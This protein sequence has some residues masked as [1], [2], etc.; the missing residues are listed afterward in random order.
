MQVI[1]SFIQTSFN[2]PRC[3]PGCCWQ[4]STDRLLFTNTQRRKRVSRAKQ[5]WLDRSGED[6]PAQTDRL[7]SG[8]TVALCQASRA[9]LILKREV[10]EQLC[11]G[12][13][14]LFSLVSLYI[15]YKE[16]SD[17]CCEPSV[18]SSHKRFCAKEIQH[19]LDELWEIVIMLPAPVLPCIGV[20]KVHWPTVSWKET[21]KWDTEFN[22]KNTLVLIYSIHQFL[23]ICICQKP[24]YLKVG[25]WNFWK[26]KKPNL[27]LANE[28][29]NS[30]KIK[31]TLAQFYALRGFA[32]THMV[33]VWPVV[34]SQL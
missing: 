14:S 9:L 29:Y 19:C 7:H 6:C 23:Q 10:R 21:D 27:P 2:R 31:C 13:V 22:S 18:S 32:A 11:T 17:W 30:L 26:K 34:V 33:L 16:Y 28:K 5:G 4:P 15:M 24:I 1:F 20:V 3:Y 25:L 12:H 8:D